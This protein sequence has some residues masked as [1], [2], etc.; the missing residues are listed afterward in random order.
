[1]VIH[2]DDAA[3]AHAA[4]VGSRRLIS[5]ASLA[6][7]LEGYAVEEVAHHHLMVSAGSV[8]RGTPATDPSLL[9]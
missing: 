1:M 7:L 2:F 4:V 9:Q 5:L 6:V 3:P 8:Q